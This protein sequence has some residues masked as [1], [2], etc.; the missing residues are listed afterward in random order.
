ME[1]SI[2]CK[3]RDDEETGLRHRQVISD[4]LRNPPSRI[5]I[6]CLNVHDVELIAGIGLKEALIRLLAY[7]VTLSI[8]V[9]EKPDEMSDETRNFFREIIDHGGRIYRHRNIHAKVLLC[10]EDGGANAVIT[11]ANF[12]PTGLHRKY[13]VG[14]CLYDLD[15][16]LYASLRDFTNFILGLDGTRSVEYYNI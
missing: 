7:G 1:V 14:T 4:L 3:R 13:E 11:S 12:T 16:E 5:R 2:L 6:V 10:E 15:D 9:G 8:V